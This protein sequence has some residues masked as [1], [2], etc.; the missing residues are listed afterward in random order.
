MYALTL[1]ECVA[2]C[3]DL[4]LGNIVFTIP[5]ISSYMVEELNIAVGRD[6]LVPINA[7]PLWREESN[8][9][10]HQAMFLV[11]TPSVVDM[12]AWCTSQ[13]R[14]PSVRLIDF[15]ESIY[16]LSIRAILGLGHPCPL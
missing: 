11:D 5:N 13:L 4:H 8:L 6:E 3:L 12:W 7:H 9:G 15:T 16:I 1:S 2:N 14:V 10:R